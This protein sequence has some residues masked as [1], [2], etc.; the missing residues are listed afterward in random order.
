[1]QFFAKKIF[2]EN[3]N[4]RNEPL[5][6]L[7]NSRKFSYGILRFS[8]TWGFGYAMEFKHLLK[9]STI[10]HKNKSLPTLPASDLKPMI[11]KLHFTK[12]KCYVNAMCYQ[13]IIKP[14]RLLVAVIIM[15]HKFFMFILH[16]KSDFT[17]SVKFLP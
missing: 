8:G 10:L 5:D 1:M 4:D 2:T 9:A 12:M 15:F 13:I 6:W 17:E 11:N 7:Y 16:N 14:K 3:Q